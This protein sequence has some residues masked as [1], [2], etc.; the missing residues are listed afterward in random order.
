MTRTP[1]AKFQPGESGNPKGR[2]QAARAKFSE[3]FIKALSD[4]FA[5]HGAAVIQKCRDERP[6][7]YLRVMAGLVPK[8]LTGDAASIDLGDV[9]TTAGIVAAMNRIV[10]GV[11]V[12]ELSIDQAKGLTDLIEATRKAIETN[13]LEG[14]LRAI[15]DRAGIN[16]ATSSHA[17]RGT[18][19]Q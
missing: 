4:D 19:R 11:S 17:N 18:A 2:P 1:V 7:E 8:A 9:S 16:G 3:A 14:R 5:S 13:D 12:G 6:G 10:S 15:E